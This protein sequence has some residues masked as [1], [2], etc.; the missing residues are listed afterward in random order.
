MTIFTIQSGTNWRE[1]YKLLVYILLHDVH[2][3]KFRF[4][5]LQ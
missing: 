2:G 4:C 3:T 5:L 1:E